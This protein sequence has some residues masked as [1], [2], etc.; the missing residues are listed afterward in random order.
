[1][2][3]QVLKRE[4]ELGYQVTSGRYWE[5]IEKFDSNALSHIDALWLEAHGNALF[6]RQTA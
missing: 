3:E 4:R 6:D 5:F 2:T 1:M